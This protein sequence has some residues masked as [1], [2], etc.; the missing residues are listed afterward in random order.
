[1]Y[2]VISYYIILLHIRHIL[3]YEKFITKFNE[4]I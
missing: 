1:M 3:Q 2:V 4:L